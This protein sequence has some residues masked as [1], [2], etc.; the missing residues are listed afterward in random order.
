MSLMEKVLFEMVQKTMDLH[1]SSN[2]EN[3][4]IVI[5]SFD[6]LMFRCGVNTF[7]FIINSLDEC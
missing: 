3:V 1:V 5:A 6:F 2:L 7:V 4:T